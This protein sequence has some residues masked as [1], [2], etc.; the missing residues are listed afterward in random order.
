[1][2]YSKRIKY[3]V[4]SDGVKYPYFHPLHNI[5]PIGTKRYANTGDDRYSPK[6]FDLPSSAKPFTIEYETN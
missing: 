6:C 2:S 1:M 5:H 3:L 4:G